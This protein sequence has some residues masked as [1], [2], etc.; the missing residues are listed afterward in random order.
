MQPATT[1]AARSLK[2]HRGV[3]PNDVENAVWHFLCV[4][5]A[6]SAEAAKAA[7]L[8]VGPDSRVPMRQIYEMF[9]GTLS[10]VQV[11]TAAGQALA[12]KFFAHLYL[13]LYFEAL[14]DAELA[15]EHI[16]LA[17]DDRYSRV[18]GVHAHGR[19]GASWRPAAT[20][21]RTGGTKLVLKT[22]KE[23]QM[24]TN[25][26]FVLVLL[27]SVFVGGFVLGNVIQPMEIV[28]AQSSDRV[29]ELRTYTT[30]GGKL[31]DLQTR[32]RDHTLRI[33][34]NHGMKNVGYWV[35]TDAP[36]SENTLIYMLAHESRAAAKQSWDDFRSDPEWQMAYKE[37]ERDG[38]LASN[39]VSVFMEATDF[40]PMK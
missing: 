15:L 33:F 10:P 28:R 8:P 14:G 27:T 31:D 1:T 25:K 13:G 21:A 12:A 30:P 4:A 32:F 34:E 17:A 5:R 35:P 39:V 9:D 22:P 36:L 3:N 38:R 40:S 16:E 11:L 19:P 18:G 26:R 7:L 6:E 24:L 20:V 37:S 23:E 2:S 29:F